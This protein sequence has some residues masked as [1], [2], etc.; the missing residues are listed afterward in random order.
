MGFQ[1]RG[2]CP[3]GKIEPQYPLL[4]VKGDK[5][6]Q[7]TEK[8]KTLR[9]SGESP[10]KLAGCKTT[11]TSKHSANNKIPHM[12]L[13]IQVITKNRALIAFDQN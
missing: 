13:L 6:G 3:L 2:I 10:N 4:I 11:T 9:Q 8:L 12:G 1:E 5:N 7:R